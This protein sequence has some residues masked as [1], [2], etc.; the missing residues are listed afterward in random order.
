MVQ[1]NPF[2]K[3]QATG[4]LEVLCPQTKRCPASPD[5]RVRVTDHSKPYFTHSH[6]LFWVC[7]LTYKTSRRLALLL[8]LG[9]LLTHARENYLNFWTP[10]N[11]KNRVFY[12]A[13][14]YWVRVWYAPRTNAFE[15]DFFSASHQLC[16]LYFSS[17]WQ[18]KWSSERWAI[19]PDVPQLT[20][21]KLGVQSRILVY[22]FCSYR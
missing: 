17:T 9:K 21:E 8:S 11:L 7:A 20:E 16:L 4:C 3:C 14:I 12:T 18:W 22:S 1:A 13:H 6:W 5:P 15:H 2:P 19:L 10:L